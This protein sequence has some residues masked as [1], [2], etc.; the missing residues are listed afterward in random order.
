KHWRS[1][2][3]DFASP[4]DITKESFAAKFAV[5]PKGTA[6]TLTWKRDLEIILEQVV[7]IDSAPAA[8]AVLEVAAIGLDPARG[9]LTLAM[10]PFAARAVGEEFLAKCTGTAALDQ[11][12]KIANGEV[13][14]EHQGIGMRAAALRFQGLRGTSGDR[15][16]LEHNLAAAE[17]PIRLACADALRI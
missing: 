16:L 5:L 3:M 1:G 8:T 7:K 6:G 14:F 12:T 9:A 4:Q 13:K 17:M 11:L 10:A 2:K 15:A